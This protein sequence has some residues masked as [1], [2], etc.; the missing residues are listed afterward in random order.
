MRASSVFAK[1]NVLQLIQDEPES[2]SFTPKALPDQYI[3]FHISH[4]Q[5]TTEKKSNPCAS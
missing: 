2:S 5:C 1:I 3:R 4:Q